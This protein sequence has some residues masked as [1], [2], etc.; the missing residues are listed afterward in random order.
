MSDAADTATDVPAY[1][2]PPDLL[3]AEADL[4]KAVKAAVASPDGS[5]WGAT[6]RFENLRLLPVALRLAEALS[7]VN[8]NFRLLWPDA[9][10]AALA[11]REAPDLAASI[12]D[13]NQW[14]SQ[15]DPDA[16]LLAVGP[17]P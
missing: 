14:S 2:L 7:A 16:L 6:L 1:V 11:R 4:L 15:A 3:K 9:G 17:Q 12:A 13:F 5:R 8:S 10:A